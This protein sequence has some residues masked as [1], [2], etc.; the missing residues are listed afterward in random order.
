MRDEAVLGVVVDGLLDRYEALMIK[1]H[2]AEFKRGHRKA[3][4]RRV[5]DLPSVDS[6]ERVIGFWVAGIE[7]DNTDSGEDFDATTRLS[8]ITKLPR[9]E[10]ALARWTA[11]ADWAKKQGVKLPK[12]KLL[13]VETEV[14]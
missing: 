14:A 6:G 12:H 9:Y 4:A 8:E 10:R 1:T 7:E 2:N 13:F 11:F 5:P 3:S